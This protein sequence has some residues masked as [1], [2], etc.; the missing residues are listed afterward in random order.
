MYICIIQSFTTET[1]HYSLPLLKPTG[2][3]INS[4]N[5]RIKKAM[6]RFILCIT[7]TIHEFAYIIYMIS[8]LGSNILNN[9]TQSLKL[10]K[11]CDHPAILISRANSQEL[12][13]ISMSLT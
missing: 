3:F 10:F 12:L 2:N 9:Y 7:F 13:P 8:L 5:H 11:S 6:V 1:K 4:Y